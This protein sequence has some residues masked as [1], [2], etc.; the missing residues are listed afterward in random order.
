VAPRFAVSLP[1][2]VTWEI[3]AQSPTGLTSPLPRVYNFYPH[4]LTF[5]I[6]TTVSISFA[7]AGLGNNNPN[8]YTFYYHN[9][10]TG[11]WE[12]QETTV[13]VANQRFIVTLNHF[14]RYAF[15]R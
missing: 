10:L 2:L 4:L 6:P 15:A 8:A 5:L 13:D 9:Q 12:P 14:S 7:D 3:F 1:T 11:Q